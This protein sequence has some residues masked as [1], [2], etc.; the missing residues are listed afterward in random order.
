MQ[1]FTE[2]DFGVP[3]VMAFFHQ[4]WTHEADTPAK[5]VA[6]HLPDGA[7]EYALA[8]RRDARALLDG[9]P[10]RTLE[11][12]WDAGTQ[13]GMG[14]R[15]TT[16]A[17]WTQ[18]VVDVCDTWLSAQEQPPRPLTGA[19]T[20]DGLAHLGAVVAEIE[21]MAFLTAEVRRALADCARACTPDL[22]LRILLR[23]IE[24]DSDASLSREQYKRLEDIGS[25]LHYGEFVVPSVEFLIADD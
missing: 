17:G 13:Y 21:G 25:A 2:F 20:E 5:L 16:G 6:R 10:S 7:G 23:V 14:W 19:D 12:L 1:R 11:V 18:T 24:Y 22:A 15:Q 3:W 8:V 4:D 9:L